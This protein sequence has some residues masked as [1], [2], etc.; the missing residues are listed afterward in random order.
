MKATFKTNNRPDRNGEDL[1]MLVVS[2]KGFPKPIT[3]STTIKVKPEHWDGREIKKGDIQHSN[4]NL[5][6]ANLKTLIEDLPTTYRVKQIPLTYQAA[7]AEVEKILGNLLWYDKPKQK[8]SKPTPEPTKESEAATK[9]SDFFAFAKK[10]LA[11]K[12]D[13]NA[14]G[15]WKLFDE[16]IEMVKEYTAELDM[17]DMHLEW[18]ESF[19]RY[20]R[21]ERGKSPRMRRGKLRK[22]KNLSIITVGKYQGKL[23]TILNEAEKRKKTT[24]FENYDYK[25]LPD[26]VTE[27]PDAEH[28]YLKESEIEQLYNHQFTESEQDLRQA[29]DYMVLLCCTGLRFQDGYRIQKID[30]NYLKLLPKK[31]FR[32]TGEQIIPYTIYPYAAEILERYNFQMPRFTNADFNKLIKKAAQVAGLKR[33]DFGKPI[34]ELISSHTGRRSLCTNLYIHHKWPASYVMLFSGHKTERDFFKYIKAKP[35]EKA[36][37]VLAFHQATK[38]SAVRA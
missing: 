10:V 38:G 23:I 18:F 31:V 8:K 27:N 34:Y 2:R 21:E 29:R 16:T 9:P 30:E 13:N 33:V 17:N 7:V 1:L 36:Q 15:T 22:V 6:L 4:K 19:Y 26:K 14:D 24:K 11:M 12:K 25:L 20:L 35:H 3:R 37:T 32:K 5:L 28:I